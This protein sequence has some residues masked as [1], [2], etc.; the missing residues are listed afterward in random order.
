MRRSLAV[1]CVTAALAAGCDPP[2]P[3]T[4]VGYALPDPAHLRRLDSVALVELNHEGPPEGL[5]RDMTAALAKS[6][7]SRKLFYTKVVR[8]EDPALETTALDAGPKSVQELAEIRRAVG[9]NAVLLG[10]ITHF[11]QYPRMQIGLFLQLFDLREGR[12]VWAL[13]HTWDTT[14]RTT[15]ERIREY[16]NEK[17]TDEYDPLEWRLAMLSPRVFEKYVAHEVAQTL[18][19]Q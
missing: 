10:S 6:I 9:C 4:A 11:E 7:G 17:M 1:A 13:E 14:D 2:E 5:S 19:Q 8:R 18:S 15:E 12:I 3:E 16:F